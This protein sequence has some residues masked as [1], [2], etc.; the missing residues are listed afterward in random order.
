MKHL[1]ID[2]FWMPL[3]NDFFN[4]DNAQNTTFGGTPQDCD[5]RWQ[6]S[7]LA[8]KR[9]VVSV[10]DTLRELAP[11]K[12]IVVPG[13]HDRQKMFYFGDTLESWYGRCDNVAVE[14]TPRTRKYLAYGVNLVGFTHG[15]EEKHPDLPIIMAQE[16]PDAW[17]VTRQREWHVGHFHKRKLARYVAGDTHGGVAIRCLPSL[18]G[19]DAWH[20]SK[21]V[22]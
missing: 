11:V 12:V 3:G 21:G 6:K 20:F 5:T 9:A 8:M 13:N 18:S 16:M 1:P 10:I 2:E 17:A 4:V 19:T 22:R 15:D 14:N 7:F